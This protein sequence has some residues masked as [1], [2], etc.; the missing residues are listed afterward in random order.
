[1]SQIRRLFSPVHLVLALLAIG[2]GW[3]VCSR[4]LQAAGQQS[5]GLVSPDLSFEKDSFQQGASPGTRKGVGFPEGQQPPA[6]AGE[7]ANDGKSSAKSSESAE[8]PD[9][10]RTQ[11]LLTRSITLLREK[12]I[13]CSVKQRGM[14][15]GTELISSG[16]YLQAEGGRGGVKTEL[17][18]QT[19]NLD[20]QVKMVNDGVY[21]FRQIVTRDETAIPDDPGWNGLIQPTV[22]RVNLRKIKE[23]FERDSA[24]P[25]HWI[26][27]GGLYLFME[28]TRKSFDFGKIRNSNVKEMRV[29]VLRGV[30]KP[31]KLAQLIPEQKEL[32]LGKRSLNWKVIPRHIPLEVEIFFVAEGKLAGFPYRVVF[33]RPNEELLEGIRKIPVLVTEYSEPKLIETPLQ[34]DF[35]F[36]AGQNEVNDITDEFILSLR[37]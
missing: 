20:L 7:G 18:I 4:I 33:Y 15:F 34:S 24:W 2:L 3:F 36:N 17:T 29:Q 22:E 1:M 9:A 10:L 12:N 5:G 19:R 8:N 35:Q 30:W 14:L 21:F 6:L 28:Q 37:R 25:G 27:Y 13:R 31:E 23:V 16:S 32:I 11:E 26:A